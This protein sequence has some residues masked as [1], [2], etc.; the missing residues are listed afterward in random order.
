VCQGR[1]RPAPG[2]PPAGPE[3]EFRRT[4][5]GPFCAFLAPFPVLRV[6]TPFS[7]SKD[8]RGRQ[9]A[10]PGILQVGGDGVEAPGRVAA[11]LPRVRRAYGPPRPI[12]RLLECDPD[13]RKPAADE[14][15]AGDRDGLDPTPCEL[16]PPPAIDPL[17]RPSPPP[18]SEEHLPDLGPGDS[19]EQ[20][21][22]LGGLIEHSDVLQDGRRHLAQG[23]GQ[24]PTVGVRDCT[25]GRC[26]RRPPPPPAPVSR[27]PDL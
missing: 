25:P 24:L 23:K 20:Q 15:P 18:V 22:G 12:M 16:R 8:W 7:L 26:D 10:R 2:P 4:H 5:P 3:L 19:I 13:L 9:G 17:R 14:P 11:P 21:D 6:R 1:S 27:A